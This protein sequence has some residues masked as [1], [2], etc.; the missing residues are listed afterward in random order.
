MIQ[1]ILFVWTVKSLLNI[2]LPLILLPEFNALK[3]VANSQPV[4]KNVFNL[5]L[6]ALYF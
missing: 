3:L 5:L 6:I 2:I 4:F 1:H